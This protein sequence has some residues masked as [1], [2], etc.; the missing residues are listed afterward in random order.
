M[1]LLDYPI[2]YQME[3]NF[4]LSARMHIHHE[5][6]FSYRSTFLPKTRFWTFER[7]KVN[8]T[9]QTLFNACKK[10]L[11]KRILNQ[12]ISHQLNTEKLYENLVNFHKKQA[13]QFQ[14]DKFF[15]IDKMTQETSSDWFYN[16]C[17]FSDNLRLN[18]HLNN[19]RSF[20][21]NCLS[22]FDNFNFTF[23]KLSKEYI[24]VYFPRFQ[25]VRTW[26]F[27]ESPHRL[28]YLFI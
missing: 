5:C 25:Q 17:F 9:Y 7:E 3:E 15:P 14:F 28:K 12:L 26:F 23:C 6:I 4:T 19:D 13:Y 18:F 10:S 8:E 1:N 2:E 20:S 16:L 11:E 21:T 24:E 27:K 22:L